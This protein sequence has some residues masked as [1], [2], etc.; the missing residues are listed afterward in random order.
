MRAIRALLV[1]ASVLTVTVGT[2]AASQAMGW[3]TPWSAQI[4]RS[5]TL[6]PAYDGGDGKTKQE[7][8]KKEGHN[9]YEKHDK[10]DKKK[11]DSYQL[12]HSCN[13][14][15]GYCTNDA[16]FAPTI[17][18]SIGLTTGLIGLTSGTTGQTATTATTGTTATTATTTTTS[19][20]ATTATTATTT[21]TTPPPNEWC[22]P[23]YWFN[24][25]LD[26][27]PAPYDPATS[28]WSDLPTPPYTDTLART[29]AGVAAGAPA[30]P[31]LTYIWDPQNANNFAQWYV[32]SR[33]SV[34]ND[35]ADVLSAAAGLSW[36]DKATAT[37]PLS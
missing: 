2:T 3:E 19:T 24:Q 20:T 31:L 18:G 4:S 36:T 33:G 23:G 7:N 28:H 26:N 35:I 37:C 12:I 34:I 16:V 22:S 29:A 30:D 27:W 21:T 32:R 25:G 11:V 6:P 1:G 9:K 15:F 5:S 8:H 17:L 14:K 13:G 10:Y